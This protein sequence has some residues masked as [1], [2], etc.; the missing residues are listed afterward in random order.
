MG[1]RKVFGLVLFVAFFLWLHFRVRL[2]AGAAEGI[3][4]PGGPFGILAP[5]WVL[6]AVSLGAG[7]LLVI[8]WKK[9]RSAALLWPWL[10]I[11]AGGLANLLERL[12]FGCIMDYIAL[13]GLPFFPVFNLADILLAIGTLGIIIRWSRTSFYS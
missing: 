6:V 2:W 8:Q 7:A 9:E 12:R 11:S 5:Q 10:L 1:L 13:P 3:C 4:N